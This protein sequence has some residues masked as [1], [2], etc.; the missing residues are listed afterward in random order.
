MMDGLSLHYYT[1]TGW[2]GS[3]G[4]ATSFN[5]DDFYWTMGKCLEIEDVIKKHS[6]PSWTRNDPK[7]QIGLLVDEWGTWWD[8]EPGTIKGHLYQ[9]NSMR[10]AFV[11][12]LTLNVFHRHTD[13]IR[14]AIS[15]RW[16]TSCR[17]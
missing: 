10:D 11:A 9:Q 13:R 3:K 7:K 2:N 4:S 1:V 15:L 12:A 6:K 5:G 8:E 16:S 14:M 17:A